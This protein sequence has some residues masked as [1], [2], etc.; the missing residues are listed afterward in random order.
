M[1]YLLK[2]SSTTV[3]VL[4]DRID[5]RLSADDSPGKLSFVTVEVPPGSFIPPCSHDVEEECYVVLEGEL[6]VTLG[7]EERALRA[8]DAA[9]VPPGTVHAYCNKGAQ[10]VRFAAF[11]VGGPLDRFFVDMSK[12]VLE[13]P[14]DAAAMLR[15]MQKYG[16]R[17]ARRD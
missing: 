14:R 7:D 10:P 2:D 1:P 4:G 11:G 3:Q 13:M 12:A 16:V 5:I 6:H 15:L 9:H 17:P 8:G